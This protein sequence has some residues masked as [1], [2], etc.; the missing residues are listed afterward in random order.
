MATNIK[1]VGKGLAG[2]MSQEDMLRPKNFDTVPA[3]VQAMNHSKEQPARLTEGEFI[4]SI[5]AII[6]LGDGDHKKGLQKLEKV[7]AMLRDESQRY[8]DKKQATDA[9]IGSV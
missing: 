4:F 3:V 6:A 7:H 1:D 2:L 8:L 5:P 9:G